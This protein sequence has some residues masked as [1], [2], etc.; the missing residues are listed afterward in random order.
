MSEA[1]E[2]YRIDRVYSINVT[3]FQECTLYYERRCDDD[4]KKVEYYDEED[5]EDPKVKAVRCKDVDAE[6]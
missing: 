2:N 3:L 4:V 6:L 1:N 5:V